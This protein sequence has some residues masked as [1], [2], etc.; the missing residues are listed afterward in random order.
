MPQVSEHPYRILITGG[1]GC[2][3]TNSFF[4]LIIQQ[5]NVDEIYLYTKNPF[6]V[7]YQFL[8]NK[9]ENTGWNYSNDTK[10]FIEYENDMDNIYKS[11][12]GYNDNVW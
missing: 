7:K 12:E 8:I 11:F 6:E 10:A 9:K 2:G 1:S 4:H 3:K 5:Q